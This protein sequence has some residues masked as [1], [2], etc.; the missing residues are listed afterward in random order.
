MMPSNGFCRGRCKLILVQPGQ[1]AELEMR[2]LNDS[3]HLPRPTVHGGTPQSPLHLDQIIRPG[4]G[5]INS[6]R[7]NLASKL[8]PGNYLG[9]LLYLKLRTQRTNVRKKVSS[10]GRSVSW[11]SC[12]RREPG[13]V[14]IVKCQ[15]SWWRK[16]KLKTGGD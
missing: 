12:W 4:E 2:D 10:R 9:S 11:W 13:V 6:A 14:G 8:Q 16:L 3:G 5:K 7:G 1:T 15:L